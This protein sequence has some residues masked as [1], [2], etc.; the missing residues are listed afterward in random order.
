L[1]AVKSNTIELQE[2]IR[3]RVE[4]EDS[5]TRRVISANGNYYLNLGDAIG[6]EKKL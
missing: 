2:E 4:S 1:V 5:I 6:G 3:I